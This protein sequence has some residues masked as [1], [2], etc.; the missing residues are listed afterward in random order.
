MIENDLSL[1]KLKSLCVL[2]IACIILFW[3]KFLLL[4]VL[5]PVYMLRT[6]PLYFN[7]TAT[8]IF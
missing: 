4:T 3:L 6:F 7:T 2:N 5:N 8:L 1:V